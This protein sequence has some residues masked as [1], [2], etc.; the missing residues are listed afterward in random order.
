MITVDYEDERQKILIKRSLYIG[1]ISVKIRAKYSFNFSM[2][3]NTTKE[4]T[5]TVHDFMVRRAEK[6]LD[7]KTV[8]LAIRSKISEI[9]SEIFEISNTLMGEEIDEN[10]SIK[11]DKV[12]EKLLKAF[13]SLRPH[14]GDL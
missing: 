1:V 4:T 14:L 9:L 3:S 7:D 10:I 11:R 12:K 5:E 6:M 2:T 13:Q 8:D